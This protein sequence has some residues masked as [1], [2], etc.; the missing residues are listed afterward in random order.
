MNFYQY[1][2]LLQFC[3]VYNYVAVTRI[4]KN[5]HMTPTLV[6]YIILSFLKNT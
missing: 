1:Y 2:T 6:I 5:D 3:V 4:I